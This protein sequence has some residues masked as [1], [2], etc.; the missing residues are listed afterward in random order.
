MVIPF[1]NHVQLN[2]FCQITQTPVSL[3]LFPKGLFL[4]NL[5][6]HDLCPLQSKNALFVLLFSGIILLRDSCSGFLVCLFKCAEFCGCAL[7]LLCV[8]KCELSRAPSLFADLAAVVGGLVSQLCL[9]LE[10]L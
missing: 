1:L 6:Q 3:L 2:S 7:H 8:S 9:T 5:V 10:T 4:I